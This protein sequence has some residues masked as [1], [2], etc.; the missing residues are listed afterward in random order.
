M[1]SDEAL[2]DEIDWVD[3]AAAVSEQVT[4]PVV[5]VVDVAP[6]EA[7]LVT[8]HI[9]E[10]GDHLGHVSQGAAACGPGKPAPLGLEFGERVDG[11]D[12]RA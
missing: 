3:V 12:L 6:V 1:S 2:C 9:A 11:K 5:Q 10:L 4:E 8:D 7:A